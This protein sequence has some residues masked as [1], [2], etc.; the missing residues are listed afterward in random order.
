MSKRSASILVVD[1]E[2][3]NRFFIDTSRH[4]SKSVLVNKLRLRYHSLY[5]AATNAGLFQQMAFFR[6][7]MSI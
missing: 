2:V 1:D 6:G 7:C 3:V 4:S 5:D